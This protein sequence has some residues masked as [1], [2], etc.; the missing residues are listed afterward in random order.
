MAIETRLEAT[1]F[2]TASDV[3]HVGPDGVVR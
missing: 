3:T 1:V 2:E